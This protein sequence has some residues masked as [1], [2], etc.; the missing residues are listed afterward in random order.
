MNT[1]NIAQ[2]A[3]MMANQNRTID[4]AIMDQRV[5]GRGAASKAQAYMMGNS[6]YGDLAGFN[7]QWTQPQSRKPTQMPNFG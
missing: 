6:I 4:P 3:M 7:P 1:S 2:G 5:Q